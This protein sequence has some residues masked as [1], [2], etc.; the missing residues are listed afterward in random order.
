MQRSTTRLA[1]APRL[2]FAPRRAVCAIGTT[3]TLASSTAL[4][5]L[6]STPT[7]RTFS[8]PASTAA[9]TP[10][11]DAAFFTGNP[12]YFSL[13]LR[14]NALVRSN[15][16]PM[17]DPAVYADREDLPKWMTRMEMASLKQFRLTDSM[18][19]DLVHKLNVL[20]TVPEK[21]ESLRLLLQ[22]YVRP[23]LDLVAP[24]KPVLTIDEFG[25]AF[26]RGSRK[27]ATAQTWLVKGTGEVYVNGIH[28]ADYF[29]EVEDRELVVRPFEI[30]KALGRYNVWAVVEGGG[31]SGQ[32]AAV[33]VAVAR[34][35][36]IHEPSL[37]KTFSEM[38]LTKID[39][40]QVE[41]KKTGQPKARKKNTWLKR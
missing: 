41:R 7:I 36:A 33:A 11:A 18:Y 19:K 35:L 31:Q 3:P 38:G 20:F 16:L 40:R 24:A 12:A 1:T 6:V 22:E 2:A 8:V 34:A 14:L 32:A 13:L 23:G 29:R 26:A 21:P 15:H 5:P 10:V 27:T 37:K 30:G 28:I 39:R 25:R 4:R 9:P 17:Q